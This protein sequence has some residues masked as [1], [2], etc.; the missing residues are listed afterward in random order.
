MAWRNWSAIR[1]MGN[2][3]DLEL[4]FAQQVEQQI[5]WAGEGLQLHHETGTG[6]ERSGRS[7]RSRS[8]HD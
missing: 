1:A 6:S 2:V 8:S 7:L 4:L 5:Q 3:G